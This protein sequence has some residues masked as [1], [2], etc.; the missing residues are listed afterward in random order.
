M[1]TRAKAE[2]VSEG[3]VR[4]TRPEVTL[5]IVGERDKE[6]GG[7][8][9]SRAVLEEIDEVM[10][11]RLEVATQPRPPRGRPQPSFL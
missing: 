3:R 11:N 10:L 6:I 9:E 8:H 5:P 1:N 2:D 4:C 7:A